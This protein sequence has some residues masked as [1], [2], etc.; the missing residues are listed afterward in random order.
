MHHTHENNE[1]ENLLAI[2][3]LNANMWNVTKENEG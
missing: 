3:V 2:N 1:M